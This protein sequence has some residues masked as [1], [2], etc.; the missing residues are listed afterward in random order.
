MGRLGVADTQQ[1]KTVR[2]VNISKLI[3][4]PGEV[5]LLLL[6]LTFTPTP[7]ADIP[8]LEKDVYEFVRKLRLSYHFRNSTYKDSSILKRK[9]GF[10]PKRNANTE[11]EKIC[12]SLETMKICVKRSPDN[13]RGLRG[14]LQSLMDKVKKQDIVIKPADKGSI[15]VLMSPEYYWQMCCRHLYEGNHYEIVESDPSEL[16]ADRVTRFA[17]KHKSLLTANEFEYLA[18]EP[19]KI[20]NFYMLPKLHKSQKISDLLKRNSNTEYLQVPEEQINDL[21]GRPINS[22][23]KYHTR[24]LSTMVHHIL[25]PCLEHIPYILKDTYDFQ[26]K[27]P[28]FASADTQF[29]TWDIKS[30]YTNISHQLFYDA[31]TYWMDKLGS[32]IP[33]LSRFSKEFV[34]EAL[35]IILEFNYF[36]INSIFWKQIVGTA[37]GTP[38]A[39]VG[40]NLVVAYLE[41]KMFRILPQLYPADFVDFIIRSYFRFLDDLI[42]Q[43]LKNFNIDDMYKVINELD[44]NLK[45]VMSEIARHTNFMDITT[46]VIGETVV[47]DMYYKPTNAFNYV[48][49]SSCHP[50]HTRNNIALSL[51]RRIVK[52]VSISSERKEERIEELKSHLIRRDFPESVIDETLLKTY[53]PSPASKITDPIVFNHVYNPNHQIN[54]NRITNCLEGIQQFPMKQAFQKKK[55]LVTTRQPANLRRLLVH[56]KFELSPNPVEPVD[57]GFYPCGN[58]VYCKV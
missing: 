35:T 8:G 44:P 12:H 23:P 18:K 14:S 49:Y 25:A 36:K 9:S 43:W 45:F 17:E 46:S 16:V 15:I 56:A 29:V 41:I 37:M 47:F 58:C 42:H 39:V 52:L 10:C 7:D 51:A 1:P 48:K 4:E 33:L 26:A 13:I 11:L 34:I 53:S 3:L 32:K 20:A 2:I 5:Q 21:E 55:P 6:G 40:S 30:L 57:Y 22:G 19:C 24:G 28:D 38:A 54:T 50:K 31:V 27:F